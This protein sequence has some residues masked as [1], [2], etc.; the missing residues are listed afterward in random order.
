MTPT[1]SWTKRYLEAA[2]RSIPEDKRADVER[3]L[4]SSI[5]DAIDERVGN[6]EDPLAAERAVLEGLGDPAKLA[7][8]YTGKPN[9]LIGPVLFPIYRFIIPRLM[10]AGAPIAGVILAAVEIL[11]GGSYGDA[12][13]AGISGAIAIAIQ[14]AFW[15]TLIFVVLERADDA[16][17]AR[18]QIIAKTGQW[19]LDYLPEPVPGRVTAGEAVG[20]VVTNFITIGGLFLFAEFTLGGDAGSQIPLASST[21]TQLWFPVL[22]GVLI[23]L[24]ALQLVVYVAGRWTMTL[25]GVF[26]ALEL[27]WAIP[28]VWLALQ[29][30]LI[31]PAFAAHVDNPDLAAGNGIV[32]LA[33]A[34]GTT[35]AT[36]WEIV[37][38][39]LRAR[40]APSL[41]SYFDT[42]RRSV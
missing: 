1:T 4:R 2:L 18:E 36:G 31:N 37:S 20:E 13:G 41:R 3:E 33:V 8:G 15:G 42:A 21:F 30:N 26:A 25:A 9:Y 32:S 38:A 34:V 11:R 28:I 23:G 39:F 27:L 16:R 29:G 17:N 19:K 40:N 35:L 10:A 5:T 12:L 6:G 24:I 14:I 22:L 7:S